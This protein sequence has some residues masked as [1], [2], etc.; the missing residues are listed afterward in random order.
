MSGVKIAVHVLY[1][2]TGGTRIHDNQSHNLVFYQLNYGHMEQVTGFEPV[3]SAWQA[4]ILPLYYTCTKSAF[5]TR[6]SRVDPAW[7]PRIWNPP[8]SDRFQW[9]GR[10]VSNPQHPAWKA[11]TLPIELLPHKQVTLFQRLEVFLIIL[12]IAVCDFITFV[13]HP[14]VSLAGEQGFEP[15]LTPSEG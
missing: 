13:I 7:F 15:W 11:S 14:H 5:T 8:K 6:P 2:V 12:K 9:S 4:E 10:R 3:P 1:G